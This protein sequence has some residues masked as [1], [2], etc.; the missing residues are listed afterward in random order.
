MMNYVLMLQV[1]EDDKFITEESL[2]EAGI[3]T[4]VKFLN[5]VEDLE[6]CIRREGMPSLILLN[7]RGAVHRGS[8]LLTRIKAHQDYA[9][10]PVIMLGEVTTPDYIKECYIAGASSYIIKPSTVRETL[11]KIE[12]FFHYWSEVA[13]V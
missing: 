13:E 12:L 1:D 4:Q 3:S 9:H 5:K 11:K 2:R 8:K 7:D 10:I 6:S